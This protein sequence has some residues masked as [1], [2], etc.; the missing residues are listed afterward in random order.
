MPR[1]TAPRK[2]A[3]VQALGGVCDLVDDPNHV[4][5]RAAWHAR[6]GACH[7]DQFGLAERATDWRG[8]NNIA[9]S[10]I[11]QMALE[12]DPE[13]TWIVCGAGTG[14][15]SATIGRY[16]RYRRLRTRLC[17]A[18]P[19]GSAFVHGWRGTD[20]QARASQPTLIEGIGRPRVEPGFVFEVVDRV[21][22]VP[23]ERSIAAAWLLESLLGRRY[24]GSSGTNFIACV[25]LAAQM[26]ANGER[27][28]IVSLLCDR[29]ERYEQTVFDT[30]WLGE[31]GIDPRPGIAALSQQLGLEP[32]A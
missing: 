13:P 32:R 31:R 19:A 29:G 20:P 15:T 30:R 5:G 24:G 8:N 16:L 14:G 17:V 18:E 26:H 12:P 10:I 21:I 2:I 7:L 28:S 4:H 1:C 27:G 6:R 11:G 22:E 9:E 3:D 23:D 25:E